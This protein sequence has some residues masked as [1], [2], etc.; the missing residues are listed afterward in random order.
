MAI[1]K[2]IIL[3]NLG[4]DPEVRILDNG[5]KVATITVA[6]TEKGY[7]TQSGQQI[8]EKTYWHNI[9]LW[10]QL[11]EVV[12]KYVSKGDKIY[13]EGKITSRSYDKQDGSKGYITEIVAEKVELLGGRKEEAPA[14]RQPAQEQYTRANESENLPF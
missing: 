12:E 7:T 4:K 9:V 5:M 8:P 1:N 10:K 11:A 2:A 13:V 3:G 14:Q 6:T